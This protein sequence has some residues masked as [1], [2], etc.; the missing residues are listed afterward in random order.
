MGSDADRA[1][2]I[3]VCK[4]K[5]SCSLSACGLIVLGRK[6]MSKGYRKW[7]QAK[8]LRKAE[9]AERPLHQNLSRHSDICVALYL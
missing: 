7:I 5:P 8:G 1:N 6:R 3:V 4:V 9:A 2:G